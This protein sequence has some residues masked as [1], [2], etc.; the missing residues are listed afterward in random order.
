[1]KIYHGSKNCFKKFDLERA[2]EH[3]TQE[4]VG[5]YCTDNKSVAY[6]YGSNGYVMTYEFKGKKA[7]SSKKQTVSR[8]EWAK[9]ILALDKED[10]FL[11]NYGDIHWEGVDSVLNTALDN[12]LEDGDDDVEILGGICNASGSLSSP[13][14]L[15]YKTLGYDHAII[16]ADWGNQKIYLIL[17]NKALK[18]IETEKVV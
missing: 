11:S 7:I 2:R 9:Y 16:D 12:L 15:F 1:M 18:L 14:E 8:K 13:I 6:R 17:N 4:G 10:E 3:G 5:F